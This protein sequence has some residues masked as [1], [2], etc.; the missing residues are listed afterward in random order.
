[1]L[2]SPH[3][4]EEV[5]VESFQAFLLNDRFVVP[6]RCRVGITEI[7]TGQ[8]EHGAPLTFYDGE[9]HRPDLA[10]DAISAAQ[11]EVFLQLDGDIP[12][13]SG[14][15]LISTDENASFACYPVV[16]ELLCTTLADLPDFAANLAHLRSFEASLQDRTMAQPSA[17]YTDDLQTHAQKVRLSSGFVLPVSYPSAAGIQVG[18][19]V[20]DRQLSVSPVRFS[21]HLYLFH[22]TGLLEAGTLLTR[23]VEWGK[24]GARQTQSCPVARIE[25]I[26]G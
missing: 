4:F 10:A 19:I 3:P 22:K 13:I 16:V 15:A 1:M 14:P 17:T 6:V 26:V 21:G 25:S 11:N 2:L 5:H 23:R 8:D 12:F 9:A 18:A 24:G 7:A 20:L